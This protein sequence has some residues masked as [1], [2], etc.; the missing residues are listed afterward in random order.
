MSSK[1]PIRCPTDLQQVRI[2][3]SLI[4]RFLLKINNTFVAV[5]QSKDDSQAWRHAVKVGSIISIL[6]HFR[7][8]P[9]LHHCE[10][11]PVLVK[12]C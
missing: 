7:T 11:N 10:V 8:P 9:G 1:D 4:T 12:V 2:T 3:L 5:V 6:K